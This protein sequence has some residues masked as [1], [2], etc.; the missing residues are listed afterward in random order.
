MRS[1]CGRHSFRSGLE[2][3]YEGLKP[4]WASPL[5]IAAASL[6]PTYEGLKL[7]APASVAK[8]RK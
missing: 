1:P 3:T 8:A 2:P 6:E 7:M 5:A 4:R